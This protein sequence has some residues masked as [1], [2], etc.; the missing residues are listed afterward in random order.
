MPTRQLTRLPNVQRM[1]PGVR[2]GP[3]V[4]DARGASPSFSFSDILEDLARKGG[5]AI[6]EGAQRR[7]AGPTESFAPCPEGQQRIGNRCV[8]VDF[9]AIVP[10]GE[11]FISTQTAGGVATIGA[12]GIPAIQPDI[13]GERNGRPIRSCP[14]GAVLGKDDLCYMKGSIPRQFRKWK[15]APR[16]VFSAADAKALRRIGTLQKKVKKLAGDANMTCKKR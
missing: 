5:E 15:P 11:P 1:V 12:F 2:L 3:G 10:G 13:V 4:P 8:R 6:I 14:P 7:F 9:G 16:P